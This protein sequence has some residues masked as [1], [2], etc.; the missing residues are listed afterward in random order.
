MATFQLGFSLAATLPIVVIS[1]HE[2]TF[3]AR[4]RVGQC[5]W[6]IK[7]IHVVILGGV[8][9]GGWGKAPI[10]FGLAYSFSGSFFHFQLSN[11]IVVC[12][13]ALYFVRSV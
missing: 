1:P 9:E 5:G 6:N 12:I 10:F 3:V 7:H 11:V 8:G 4:Q 2:H 13:T